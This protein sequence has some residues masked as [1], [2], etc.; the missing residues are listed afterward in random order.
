MRMMHL[1]CYFFTQ[2]LGRENGTE[3]RN[4]EYVGVVRNY[5]KPHSCKK[6]RHLHRK[7]TA[8]LTRSFAWVP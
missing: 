8:T 2:R 5:C 3:V 6:H 1:I 7:S 4:G